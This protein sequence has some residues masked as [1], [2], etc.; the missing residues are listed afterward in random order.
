MTRKNEIPAA[1]WYSKL[2]GIILFII[3]GIIM[4]IAGVKVYSYF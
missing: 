4:I 2:L 1:T 3:L